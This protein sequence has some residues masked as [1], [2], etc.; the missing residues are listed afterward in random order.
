MRKTKNN[1]KIDI[2]A[3]KLNGIRGNGRKDSAIEI[4]DILGYKD[5]ISVPL[6][7]FDAFLVKTATELYENN[8]RFDI[9][10]MAFGLL[11]G[12]DYNNGIPI[13][14]RREKYLIESN[15]I[16]NNLRE[17]I[18]SYTDVDK[19]T[20]EQLKNNLRKGVEE[21]SI[22]DLA[23]FLYEKF[24]TGNEDI[25]KYLNTLNEYIE[26]V[27][28]NKN[29]V[30]YRVKLQIP[31]YKRNTERSRDYIE[32]LDPK[33]LK[34]NPV[35]YY[36]KSIL[37]AEYHDEE[38]EALYKA[39]GGED[40]PPDKE[41]VATWLTNCIH[42]KF[43]D[44]ID[45]DIMLVSFALLPGYELQGKD[46]LKNRLN[47]YL[48]K[49]IYYDTHP[50]KSRKPIEHIIGIKTEKEEEKRIRDKLEARRKRLVDE[51]IEHIENKDCS[52]HIKNIKGYATSSKRNHSYVPKS[53]DILFSKKNIECA[54]EIKSKFSQEILKTAKEILTA[55]IAAFCCIFFSTYFLQKYET[56][57]EKQLRKE[58]VYSTNWEKA[59]RN[60]ENLW[61]ER[62]SKDNNEVS[63]G[64]PIQIEEFTE[65]NYTPI[66]DTEDDE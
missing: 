35:S 61:T 14:V 17:K 2:L 53:Q 28:D 20:Q 66:E 57:S 13:G 25:E 36:I 27:V 16:Q 34:I 56:L 51:F 18:K 22:K 11:D 8:Y 43:K 26:K 62:A 64:E 1:G 40:A 9:L 55:S 39:L 63:Y 6:Y 44:T 33:E 45:R 48:L 52:E 42:E 5:Y 23:Y 7:Q 49:S 24:L 54:Q 19:K 31:L 10:L 50:C 65:I 38:S 47:Q 32:E 30:S 58:G 12:Y 37:E 21:T 3:S 46:G 59:E 15:H 41:W 60:Q 4:L 29:H